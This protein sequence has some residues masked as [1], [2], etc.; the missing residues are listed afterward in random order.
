[1]TTNFDV[2]TN[3][4]ITSTSDALKQFNDSIDATV[5]TGVTVDGFGLAISSTSAG[6]TI[7]FTNDGTVTTNQTT[8]NRALMID[9]GA[10]G[11]FGTF[12]YLG[13]G[14]VTNTGTGGALLVD[15][16][17]TAA[18][19]GNVD[20]TISGTSTITGNADVLPNPG[21]TWHAI[22]TSDFNGDAKADILWQNNDGLPAIWEMNGFSILTAGVLPNPGVTWHPKEDGPIAS[23]QMGATNA[24]TGAAP[25]L[26][27]MGSSLAENPTQQT[28][29][30]QLFAG[31]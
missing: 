12:T 30:R 25:Q 23:G 11:D 27:A 31:S 5:E 9:P 13:T 29:A 19:S 3:T 18:G 1:M 28:W 15:N 6:S 10:G 26:A 7:T 16:Q 8:G 2:T 22:G 20:I 4:T 17:G 21:P 14:N 24:P